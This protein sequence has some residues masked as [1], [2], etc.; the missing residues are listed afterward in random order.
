MP[1]SPQ[2]KTQ[3]SGSGIFA[4]CHFQPDFFTLNRRRG[5]G[6]AQIAQRCD[7]LPFLPIFGDALHPITTLN[8]RHLQHRVL[9]GSS[10]TRSGLTHA[11]PVHRSQQSHCKHQICNRPGSHYGGTRAQRLIVE[12][13]VFFFWLDLAFTLIQHAHIATQ[14]QHGNNVFGAGFLAGPAQQRLAKANGITQHFDTAGH[15]H[16]VVAPFMHCNQNAKR[17][18]KRNN[19]QQHLIL[20]VCNLIWRCADGNQFPCRQLHGIKTLSKSRHKAHC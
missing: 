9:R 7:R 2:L 12:R 8:T 6:P 4:R 11:H 16:A 19:S 20:L 3:G 18:D 10:Q 17:D 5:D 13:K 14:R 1:Q 15:S